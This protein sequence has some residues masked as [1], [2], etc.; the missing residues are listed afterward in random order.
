MSLIRFGDFE[1]GQSQ[2]FGDYLITE[3]EIIE[4][5]TKYDPHPFPLDAEFAKKTPFGALCASGWMTCSV[6]MRMLYDNFLKNSTSVGSPGVDSLQWRHPVYAGDRLSMSV[7]VT[8]VRA[9]ESRPNMGLVR[10]V[11]DVKN[12]NRKTVL[13]LVSL[14]MFLK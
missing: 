10:S 5:A 9:S 2:K 13:T 7:E 3:E 4:F 1:I 14:A 8:E 11:I 12:Q 6:M